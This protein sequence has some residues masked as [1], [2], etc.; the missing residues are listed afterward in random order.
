ME[1]VSSTRVTMMRDQITLYRPDR[2][3]TSC[4]LKLI[5]ESPQLSSHDLVVK[6]VQ[7]SGHGSYFTVLHKSTK[8]ARPMERVKFFPRPLAAS[9]V[10]SSANL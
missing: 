2:L 7:S 3:A 8:T 10:F 6:S 4:Y 5:S 1:V 9:D